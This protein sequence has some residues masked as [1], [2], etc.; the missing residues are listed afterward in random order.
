MS[1]A[2]IGNRIGQAV[3][4][5]LACAA[6][7]VAQNAPPVRRPVQVTVQKTW[8]DHTFVGS[9]GTKFHYVEQGSGTP[10]VLIHGLTSSAVGGWFNR[11][12]AQRLATTNRVIALDMR[13]HGDT[14]PSPA[15]SKG[16][17]IED[18]VEL[19]DYLK[20][21][22]AHIGGYS[23]GGATTAGLLKRAPERFITASLMGIGIRETDE[24]RDKG[25]SDPQPAGAEARPARTMSPE[26][27]PAG[28]PPGAPVANQDV[29]LTKIKFPVLAING[30]LDTPL[31]KTHR[32]W[33]EL[34]D[35]TYVVVPGK[36]HGQTPADPRLGE[37]LAA[38]IA[39]HNP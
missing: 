20:I 28:A 15:S 19:M 13:G 9:D 17:M 5:A 37:K 33:R 30:S 31:A 27:V 6:P 16:T 32:M 4:L 22:K 1:N 25:P 36:N 26:G 39:A 11:G 10:I 7:V 34:E 18:V 2:M 23:M 24:W 14:G 38:F 8:T 29:D 3:A 12:I 35:F 21:Q